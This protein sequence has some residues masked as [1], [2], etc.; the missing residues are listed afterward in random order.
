MN[1]TET[2]VFE[3]LVL[4]TRKTRLEE[5]VERFNTREQAR[6]YIE[7][8]GLDFADY[9]LEHANYHRA[10]AELRRSLEGLLSKLQ[11]VDRQFLPN[12]LFSPKDLIVTVGQ[13]GLVVNT[14]KYLDGQPIVAVNPDPAR[15]DGILL[16]FSPAAA[17][18]GVSRVVEGGAAVHRITMAEAVFNDG[19]RLL[20]FNDFYIGQRTHVSSRYTLG[21]EGQRERQSSSGVLV[22]TGA[23]STGWFSST[24]NMADAVTHLL[25][26][27]KAPDV[28][29]MRF[30]W[31]DPRLAF[32]V[33]EP[34][35]SKWS[36]VTIGA[37]LIDP[38]EKLAIESHMPE[39]GVVF[40]DG[41]EAD[42][43]DFNSGSV[44]DIRASKRHTVLVA[45]VPESARTRQAPPKWLPRSSIVP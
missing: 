22:A 39:S 25:L 30:G 13:D 44:V 7:H 16:P 35:R 24:Q 15:F 34:F 17:A 41:V 21:F 8:M 18:N 4:V 40:S 37:G 19:Q 33:R 29:R 31:D 12:F 5:L 43:I 6:F 3:K 42:A 38:G 27:Q 45:A 20:A 36:G 14:A 32:V 26:G 1:R 9:D 28:P 10:L 11:V 23:G 2:S